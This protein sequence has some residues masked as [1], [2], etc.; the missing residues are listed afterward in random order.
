MNLRIKRRIYHHRFRL[1]WADRVRFERFQRFEVNEEPQK[2]NCL[3]TV[4]K[5]NLVIEA[6]DG[7]T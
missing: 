6:W 4:Q 5:D 1:C 3:S 2:T 7:K